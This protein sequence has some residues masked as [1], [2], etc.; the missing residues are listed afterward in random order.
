[1]TALFSFRSIKNQNSKLLKNK[2]IESLNGLLNQSMVYGCDLHCELFNSEDNCYISE[3]EAVKICESVGTFQAIEL[4]RA[5][6]KF[7]YG[8]MITEITPQKIAY[9][10]LYIIGSDLLSN[11]EH[12][13]HCCWD[14]RLNSNDIKTIIKELKAH[15]RNLSDDL[16]EISCSN[17]QANRVY[18]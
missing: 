17:W 16:F 14:R 5:Y 12:L 10:L 15:F 13:N 1:M 9:N 6:E 8:E 4:V 11:I 3:D 18:H 2:V 7:N